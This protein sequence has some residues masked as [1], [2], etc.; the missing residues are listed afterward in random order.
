MKGYASDFTGSED[1]MDS[2]HATLSIDLSQLPPKQAFALVQQTDR[3][4]KQDPFDMG[5]AAEGNDDAELGTVEFHFT[6]QEALTILT[7]VGVLQSE[8][9]DVD[10]EENP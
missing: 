2:P 10:G 7:N 5:L 1:V 9:V 3:I 8:G 6:T 4:E